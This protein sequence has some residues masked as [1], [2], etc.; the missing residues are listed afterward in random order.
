MEQSANSLVDGAR[1]IMRINSAYFQSKVLQSA[2]Q[3]GLF[4]YLAKG[5]AT[6]EEIVRDL[7]LH[8]RL[9]ND[10]LDALVGLELLDRDQDRY[11]VDGT[12]ADYL[13]TAGEL[14]IGGTS[15]QHGRMHYHAWGELA[16][17]L[18]DGKARSKKID[19]TEGF[20]KFYE[21]TEI[22]YALMS[23]MD[24]FTRFVAPGLIGCLDWSRYTSFVDV[25]GAR[26][27]LAALLVRDQ[28]HLHG[29]VFDL[30]PVAPL[31]EEHIR[32]LG[33][34]DQV[35]FQ[36]GD[37]FT[38]RLPIG[39]VAM[40]GH[41]LHDWPTEDRR[42]I[43]KRLY[44]AVR[45]GGALLI[46]DAMLDDERRDP[47]EMLQSLNCRLLGTGA[48]EYTVAECRAY[49][50]DAGFRFETAVPI[51]TITNDKVVIARRD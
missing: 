6:V 32:G 50:E 40:I 16:D 26:G 36:A 51:P 43:V 34:E 49:V 20:L 3:I 39:D 17:A 24:T 15:A 2:V 4:E 18:R 8:P 13:T 10:F 5:P 46:Y 21:N 1:R 28:P 29:T 45:P 9:I 22:V 31:F 41:T 23:H 47:G 38:D 42:T 37:F 14:Y 11:G 19:G 44:D 7:D 25:G 12:A 27:N 48:S 35:T 30:P 33:C